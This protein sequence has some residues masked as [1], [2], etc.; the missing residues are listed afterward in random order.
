MVLP[1]QCRAASATEIRVKK[2]EWGSQKYNGNE[3]GSNSAE[4]KEYFC[5]LI[6]KTGEEQEQIR[7]HRCRLEKTAHQIE[8]VP[9]E[10]KI[11]TGRSQRTHY[12]T[13]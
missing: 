2:W 4:T 5:A 6:S 1:Q 7:A 9:A 8:N 13:N 3:I 10:F 11:K 12:Q